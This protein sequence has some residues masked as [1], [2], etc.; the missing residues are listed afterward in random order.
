MNPYD[1]PASESTPRNV[2]DKPKLKTNLRSLLIPTFVGAVIG[3]ILL[4]PV[5]RG[6]G[7][8]TGHGIAFGLGGL[9]SLLVAI[10]F[11]AFVRSKRTVADSSTL[12]RD[13]PQDILA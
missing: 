9:V 3:S 5:T 4:A 10:A 2:A 6:P 1:P 13:A 8:P 12:D 11:R 7:D